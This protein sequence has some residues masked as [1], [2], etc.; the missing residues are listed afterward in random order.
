MSS[1][2]TTKTC[3]KERVREGVQSFCPPGTYE[4]YS[5]CISVHDEYVTND[6]AS[7]YYKIQTVLALLILNVI[8]QRIRIP[9][10]TI[11][12]LVICRICYE[13]GSELMNVD[14]KD[15]DYFI[16]NV[17]DGLGAEL[18]NPSLPGYYHLGIY[19]KQEANQYYLSSGRN[20]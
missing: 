11:R 6:E 10:T 5:K 18:G 13:H 9:K 7:R 19:Q 14:N 8:E 4:S 2:G 12:F 1:D 17:L 16:T 3:S 20:V 15:M